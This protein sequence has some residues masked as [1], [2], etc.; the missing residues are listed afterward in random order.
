MIPGGLWVPLDYIGFVN[1]QSA[2]RRR[3]GV[4][5]IFFTK[6]VLSQHRQ[7]QQQPKKKKQQQQQRCGRKGSFL[8]ARTEKN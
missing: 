2:R 4:E 7:Q 1:S 8:V 3:I 6:K 5:Y